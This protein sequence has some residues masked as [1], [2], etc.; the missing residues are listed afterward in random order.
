M[1][2]ERPGSDTRLQRAEYRSAPLFSR[3]PFSGS[4]VT[5]DAGCGRAV[6]RP[7]FS[8]TL[9]S[10][11]ECVRS[12]WVRNLSII[13]A[14]VARSHA[15]HSRGQAGA[16]NMTRPPARRPTLHWAYEYDAVSWSAAASHARNVLSAM[17]LNTAPQTPHRWPNSGWPYADHQN[18][19]HI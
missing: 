14:R 8:A 16:L 12:L 17:S 13:P 10:F 3:R 2:A 9:S 7:T 6:M 4:G 18:T 15:R 19:S 1:V 5:F 11:N